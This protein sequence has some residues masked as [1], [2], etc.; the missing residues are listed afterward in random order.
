MNRLIKFSILVVSLNSGDKLLE[1]VKSILSQT[2]PDYEVVVKDGGSKDASIAT[3]EAYLQT[4]PAY[5]DK[6][7]ITSRKD[8]GIYEGMNQA[9]KEAKGE[10]YYFLN[11][12]DLF[13]DTDVLAKISEN[14]DKALQQKSSAKIFYGN[15]YDNLREQIVPSNP[16]IDDFGCYRNVPCHQTCIYHYSLFEERGYEPKYRVR[17]DY[18]HFLWCY[19]CKEAKPQYIDVVIASYEG[20]GFSETKENRR[21][22]KAEHKEITEKYMSKGQLLRY[23]AVM[24]VT[25]APLRT[26]MAE[27]PKW[28][29]FYNKCKSLVYRSK[30]QND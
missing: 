18:E 27:S 10:Y 6:V 13:A 17:A 14:I 21:R 29:G 9:T 15:I 24:A 20:G 11:C 12:G 30:K 19:F 23:K 3:L 28:A 16:K 2:C 7:R 5:A 4:C 1:T 22:S 26:K 8:T 25:L